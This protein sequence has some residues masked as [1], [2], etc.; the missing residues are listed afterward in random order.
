[1]PITEAAHPLSTLSTFDPEQIPL[2]RV[3][4]VQ[5]D[6]LR[7]DGTVDHEQTYQRRQAVVALRR[8]L[9]EKIFARRQYHAQRRRH[10]AQRAGLFDQMR[11]LNTD[12]PDWQND[13][14]RARSEALS[15][16]IG[17]CQ[18]MMEQ[19]RMECWVL[20]TALIDDGK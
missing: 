17:L 13:D 8:Q 3:F 11:A 10:M 7:P 19:L 4:P 1:M 20:W 16:E 5:G 2:A 9:V 14:V 6:V 18:E 12:T 15:V